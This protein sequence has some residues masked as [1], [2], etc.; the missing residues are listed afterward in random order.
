[1]QLMMCPIAVADSGNHDDDG[2]GIDDDGGGDGDDDD[3]DDDD[4]DFCGYVYAAKACS[5]R[6]QRQEETEQNQKKEGREKKK[7]Q[8]KKVLMW[9][10]CYESDSRLRTVR[11]H[12]VLNP[13]SA[14]SL[15]P[16]PPSLPPAPHPSPRLCL[17]EADCPILKQQQKKERGA[18]RGHMSKLM[19]Q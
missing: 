10:T 2:G 14:A 6:L 7:K 11:L 18:T 12:R 16:L 5:R 13:G 19:G 15:Y 4:D 17:G 9:W 3:D 8:K 1:M